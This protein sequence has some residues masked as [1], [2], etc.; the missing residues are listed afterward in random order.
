MSPT[1]KCI[2]AIKTNS[3]NTC[4]SN[5]PRSRALVNISLFKQFIIFL[6]FNDSLHSVLFCLSFRYTAKWLENQVLYEVIPSLLQAPTG[7]HTYFN[8]PQYYLLYSLCCD[9]RLCDCFCNSLLVGH[10]I[11]WKSEEAMRPSGQNCGET[12]GD[13]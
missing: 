5:S 1:Y 10:S 12:N 9:L 8:L 11:F 4:K 3:S 2:N 13:I 7:P 6:F